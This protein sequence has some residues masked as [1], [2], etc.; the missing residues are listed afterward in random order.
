[1][2]E[3]SHPVTI[4]SLHRTGTIEAVVSVSSQQ[5]VMT[6]QAHSKALIPYCSSNVQC[7][8]TKLRRGFSIKSGFCVICVHA[9]VNFADLYLFAPASLYQFRICILKKDVQK[10][11]YIPEQWR[12]RLRS[13]DKIGLQIFL[14][15]FFSS[16]PEFAQLIQN[17]VK[18]PFFSHLDKMI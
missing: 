2:E 13:T 18:F 16:E 12:A 5:R 4:V 11:D 15:R 7:E 9:R 14:L 17:Y 6:M 3:H 8:T 10:C 1:M